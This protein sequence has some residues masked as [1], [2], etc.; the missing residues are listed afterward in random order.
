MVGP[1]EDK[2]VLTLLEKLAKQLD[3]HVTYE[4]IARV[5]GHGGLCRVNGSFRIIVDKRANTLDRIACLAKALATFDI[6]NCELDPYL[7][8]LLT[9]YRV[10]VAS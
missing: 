10:P 4:S 5:V 7:D 3:V 2:Q 1:V 8:Q 6:S 9:R